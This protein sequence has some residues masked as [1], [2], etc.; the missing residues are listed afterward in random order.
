ML[1]QVQTFPEI[2]LHKPGSHLSPSTLT[3]VLQSLV[4][5]PLDPMGKGGKVQGVTEGR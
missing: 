5:L 4:D 1:H 2:H 3:G